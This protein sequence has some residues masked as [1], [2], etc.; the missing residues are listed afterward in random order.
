MQ[1]T[2]LFPGSFDPFTRG[3]AAVVDEALALFDRVVIAV[4]HNVAKR[5]LLSIDAR[6]RLIEQLYSGEPRV[7][8][9]VYSTLTGDEAR[10][11]GACAIIR[12]V[13]TAADFE[14]ERT[15]AQ[16]NR[17]LFPELSSVLL[18]VSPELADISSS[19]VRELMAFGR[20][21]DDLM[22]EGIRIENYLTNE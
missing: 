1:R 9:S 4:G 10:R 19:L 21:V 17:R 6:R 2:A 7:E 13:R 8:V 12:S 5:G 16:A 15:I 3:H 14:Y 20:S 18:M 11:V 22:P